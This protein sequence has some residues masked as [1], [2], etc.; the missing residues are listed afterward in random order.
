M[1]EASKANRESKA[2]KAGKVSKAGK[3]EGAKGTYGV[4]GAYEAVIG[5]EI[6]AQLKTQSKM[7]SADANAFTDQAN[8]HVAPTSLGMPGALPVVNEEAIHQALKVGLAFGSRLCLSS[9]FARKNYFYPDLPKGYQISQFDKPLCEGGFLTFWVGDR[10]KK[11]GIER[12]H[13]EEDAGKFLH[14][15]EASLVDYNRSGVP[16]LEIV[17]APDMQSGEEAS[18]YA[19]Y[20]RQLLRY[21]QVCDGNLEEGSLRCDCNISVRKKGDPQLGVKVEVKNVNSFR[22][23]E[24]AVN[25]EIHRQIQCLERGDKVEQETR[26]YHPA[27]QETQAMRSKEDAEDYRY[28]TDPDLPPLRIS[29]DKVELLRKTLP[30][31]PLARTQ[32]FQEDLKLSFYDA[33]SLTQERELADYFEQ[34]L[35]V[36]GKAKAAANWLL[37]ELLRRLNEEKKEVKACPVSTKHVGELLLLIEEKVIS[38]KIAKDLFSEMWKDPSSS[39]MGPR[40]RVETKG[41][42]QI[43]DPQQVESMVKEVLEK[44]PQQVNQYRGG[45]DKLFGFFVGQMMKLSQGKADPAWVQKLLRKHLDNK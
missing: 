26:A 43:R 29:K 17:S 5:L 39:P 16:L 44:N 19:R 7:F 23:V 25:Y 41:L 14:F 32:R 40:E 2:G 11:V 1:S 13:L 3:T 6:H 42:Q 36:C 30:E 37:T 10:L 38:G 28:F 45:K 34:V 15:K 22:F 21:L 20:V 27:K 12:A 33:H 18:A 8:T 35:A 9:C 31:L 24:K 4:H